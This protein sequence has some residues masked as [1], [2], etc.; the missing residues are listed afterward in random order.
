MRPAGQATHADITDDLSLP[1]T[2]SLV[3]AAGKAGQVSVHSG[4][5][6]LVIDHHH[7]AVAALLADERNDTVAGDLDLGAYRSGVV[8]ALMRAP[9]VQHRMEARF[10]E[11]G[12]DAG[13][14][15]GGAQECLVHALA[16]RRV[17]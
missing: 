10:A 9:F 12:T 11:T 5:M 8:H 17:I 14:L 1:N 3:D 4:K 2:L 15:D 6:S 13:K 7:V 16:F